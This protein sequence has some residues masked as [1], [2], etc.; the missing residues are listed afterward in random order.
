M[1]ICSQE[2][3][4]LLLDL[5]FFF[6]KYC[7]R[8]GGHTIKPPPIQSMSRVISDVFIPT[9]HQRLLRQLREEKRNIFSFDST[10]CKL[11][12]LSW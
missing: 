4:I 8:L 7:N 5:E 11:I 1:S 10:S 6:N 3:S 2:W 9:V 12:I